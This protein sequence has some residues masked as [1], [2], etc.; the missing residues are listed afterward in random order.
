MSAH[1][2]QVPLFWDG[3]K[4]YVIENDELVYLDET[5]SFDSNSIKDLPES[6]VVSVYQFIREKKGGTNWLRTK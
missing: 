1:Q 3:D 5:N 2:K 6:K 4:P